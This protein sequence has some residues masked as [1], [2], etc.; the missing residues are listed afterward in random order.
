MKKPASLLL[1][2][3][4]ISVIISCD[5]E[6]ENIIEIDPD[7]ITNPV[8]NLS[9][10]RIKSIVESDNTFGFKIFKEIAKGKDENICIS[11]LSISM[12]LSMAY[13]GAETETKKEME[14][15]L[16]LIGL[17]VMDVN[18]SY[19]ALI[20]SLITNDPKVMFEIANSIWSAKNF[21]IEDEF[22][23]RN[24]VYFDA[25]VNELDFGDPLAVDIVNNWVSDKTHQKI[26][27][28]LQGIDPNAVM[29][30]INT[31]YFKGNWLLEFD[32]N[33]TSNNYFILENGEE[34][35]VPTMRQQ[36]DFYVSS[37]DL[38]S[39]V[40]LLYGSGN[41]SMHILLPQRNYNTN[42]IID[43]LNNETW[44]QLLTE[45]IKKEDYKVFIPKFK[46]KYDKSI[47]N[48]LK[49]F[50]MNLA[51]TPQ[52]D[53]T[54][55]HK[56]GGVWF[57]EVIH[58]TFIEVNEEGTEAAAVTGMGASLGGFWGFQV[59]K[60]FIFIIKERKTNAILF[61]GKVMN[62]LEN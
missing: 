9:D 44:N 16:E 37:N 33:H 8:E 4:F 36:E 39:S 19:Q 27:T 61:I 12:C 57:S 58:K 54:S 18:K 60:P 32:P 48:D 11:P 35:K 59:Y 24:E 30:L 13:N 14:E 46:F 49:T 21:D 50:G 51:F 2:M 31:I 38:F 52:A 22:V 29:Y 56:N 1:L 45:Y 40:E 10:P 6:K 23:R 34:I 47:I 28:I 55:I 25:E 62:P 5:K 53:F 17:S 3:F 41:F 15:T 42:D 43:N 20:D 26:E 7:E